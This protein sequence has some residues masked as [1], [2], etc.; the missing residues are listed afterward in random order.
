MGSSDKVTSIQNGVSKD[1]LPGL[2]TLRASSES[3]RTPLCWYTSLS[4]FHLLH[5]SS[6]DGEEPPRLSGI[7]LTALGWASIAPRL[8]DVPRPHALL[9]VT[10]C[11]CNF[12]PLEDLERWSAWGWYST[13]TPSMRARSGPHIQHKM[14]CFP[15]VIT[16]ADI[17]GM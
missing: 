11:A 12:D 17:L 9:I 16:I 15:P 7:N 14:P 3:A 6:G 1:P 4:R 10:F 5:R 8:V 2:S 13:L